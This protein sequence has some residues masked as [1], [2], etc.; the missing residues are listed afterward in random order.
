VFALWLSAY[1]DP[2]IRELH[3]FQSWMYLAGVRLSLHRCRWGYFVGLSAAGL[4][5]YI[6]V[7]VNPFLRNGL[8]WLY[9]SLA[10]GSLMRLDQVIAVPAGRQ[11]ARSPRIAL[12][13]QPTFRQAP[14]RSG[15]PAARICSDHC[16]FRRD[17]SHL[18][19]TISPT[20]SRHHAPTSTLVAAVTCGQP[21]QGIHCATPLC[22][23][24]TRYGARSDSEVR[25]R[26]GTWPTKL[27]LFIPTP[28]STDEGGGYTSCN[29]RR[30]CRLQ[31]IQ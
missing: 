1:L 4:W 17:Y 2:S 19:A 29:S 24:S 21:H 22:T 28:S 6:T 10:T 5:N 7:F 12:G 15:T 18:S 20:I 8:H 9:A 30:I 27:G 13:L 3:F 16:L 14:R 11:F 23:D 25:T 26:R 31:S